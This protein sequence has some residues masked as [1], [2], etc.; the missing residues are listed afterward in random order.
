MKILK[1]SSFVLAVNIVEILSVFLRNA[2][3]ARLLS[4]QD[5]GIVA[6]FTLLASF[7]DLSGQAGLDRMVVQ[8]KDADEPGV[9]ETLH[10]V[11]FGL[12]LLSGLVM[13]LICVPYASF[14]GTPD[15]L[16][17]YALLALIPVFKGLAHLDRVRM[18]RRGQF[19]PWAIRQIVPSV[20]A[21]IAI[22]PGYLVFK[23]YRAALVSIFVQQILALASSHFGAVRR[24]TFEFERS[25]MI[26]A[27]SFGWPM[28][29]NSLLLY[30]VFN[31]DRLVIANLFGLEALG[32]F[33]A[34][35]MLT[36]TP[37]NFVARTLQTTLLPVMSRSDL[38]TDNRQIQYN[39]TVALLIMASL[40]FV[41]LIFSV[42]D[43]ILVLI[44]GSRFYGATHFLQILAICQAVRLIRAA[45]A[46]LAMAGGD[47]KNPLFANIVRAAFIVFSAAAAY[48]WKNID[49]LLAIA[50][51]G[52]VVA[53]YF[54]GFLASRV[55]RASQ[56]YFFFATTLCFLSMLLIYAAQ[57]F[58]W[59]LTCTVLAAG[60]ALAAI[61]R[62]PQAFA[63]LH[64]Q[65]RP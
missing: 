30:F 29:V 56:R 54:S 17:A 36:L 52:E 6:T 55:D 13:L 49:I 19:G 10:T 47:T 51:I 46:L 12:G 4:V 38:D 23:D 40:C 11:Q 33:S 26:R 2:I 5:F 20:G 61:W 14:S 39:S 63:I 15:L 7:L 43:K 3:F 24:Y 35:I 45:P 22:Y 60:L 34:A 57:Q 65:R 18:Q 41:A 31:G 48:K 25:V 9:Q 53:T 16:P 50:V 64:R 8:A 62:L 32:L 28:T 58:A 21:L 42:G 59:P 37:I 44:L 27:V 1:S